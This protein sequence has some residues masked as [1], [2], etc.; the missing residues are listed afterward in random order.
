MRFLSSLTVILSFF[1]NAA[2][3]V[4]SEEDSPKYGVVVVCQPR[5]KEETSNHDLQSALLFSWVVVCFALCVSRSLFPPMHNT[6]VTTNNYTWLPWNVDPSVPTP[7]EYKAMLI[8]P[9]GDW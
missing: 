3:Y 2:K 6:N 1:V 4:K 9:L 5:K 7:E 8:Q